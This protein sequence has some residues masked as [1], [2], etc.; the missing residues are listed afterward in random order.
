MM[1]LLALPLLFFFCIVFIVFFSVRTG[2]TEIHQFPEGM[3]LYYE[4]VQFKSE[5]GTVLR[6]WFIPSLDAD[7]VIENGDKAL[8]QK[9]PGVVL[10][11]GNCWNRGQLLNLAAYLNQQGYEVLLFDFRACGQSEGET[12]S[13][14]LRERNDVLAAV[15]YLADQGSV[16]R[17]RIAVIGQDVGGI[18]ALGAAARDYS[19]RALVVADV[20][21]D[22]RTAI[23][24][25]MDKS[26]T[27]W[28]LF[29]T[30]YLRGYQTYF[31]VS[32]RQLSSVRTAESLSEN[33]SMLFLMR[34]DNPSL[35]ESAHTIVSHSKANAELRVIKTPYS[36][37]LTDSNRVG[38]PIVKFLETVLGE[39][40]NQGVPAKQ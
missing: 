38:P 27:F 33:Q 31:R 37:T 7:E 3:R 32:E 30:A 5:D 6:G 29:E 14:G 2:R 35:K 1:R 24:R 9:R 36:S 20:D 19:I 26:G 28:D 13:F 40:S 17:D 39:Q 25:R 22:M 21:K 23:S 15:H 4:P 11:H 18:A 8:R 16:D 12:R 10:C 34:H